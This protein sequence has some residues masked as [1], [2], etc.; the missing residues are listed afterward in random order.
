VGELPDHL[1]PGAVLDQQGILAADPGS[2][3]YVCELDEQFRRPPLQQRD[4]TVHYAIFGIDLG[5]TQAQHVG[6]VVARL[7]HATQQV[8]KLRVVVEQAQQRPSAGAGLADSKDVLG[9]GIQADDQQVLVEQDD[10]RTQ[11]V[12]DVFSVVL[13]CAAVVGVPERLRAAVA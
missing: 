8:P 11:A 7:N 3:G 2:A 6:V 5:R 13:E 1:A 10:A 9:G 12:E 4:A